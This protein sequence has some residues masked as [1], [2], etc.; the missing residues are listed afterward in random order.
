MQRDFLKTLVMITLLLFV[1]NIRAQVTTSSISGRVTDNQETI[2]GA[3]IRAKHEPTGTVYGSVTNNDGQFSINGVKT[4]GPYTIE[5][6]MFGYKPIIHNNITLS[7]GEN[8]NINANLNIDEK[9]LDEVVVEAQYSHFNANKN[10]A[11]TN[12]SNKQIENTPSIN[13]SV[14]DV[15]KMTPQAVVTGS[16]LSFA[17]SNNKYNSFQIDGSVN[18]DVFGLS[19][20]GTNGGLSGANPISLEAIEEIQVV[21]APFDVRQSGF[22]GGGINAITKS[23]TNRFTGSAYLYFN[24][25]NF[26][27]KTAG[28]D[29]EKREKLSKQSQKTYGFTLGGPIVK[30][31]LFFF[32]NF[33]KVDETYPS[34]YNVGAGS[35]ITKDEAD[36][37]IN[38]LESLT[39]GYNGGGYGEQDVD[40]KSTKVL[41]RLDWN[42]NS[43]HS[44]NVRYSYLD[45]SKL[46]Y[47]NS[48]NTLRL[49]NTG[50]NMKNKSHSFV[51]E[52]NSR[53][54]PEWYNEMRV[55]YN[56]VRDHREVLG[57]PFP[58][59]KINLLNSRAVE[60]G[61]ER[62]SPANSLDQDI[63]SFTDNLTFNKGNHALTFGTHNE[64]FI[65]KNLF[66]RENYGS[67]VYNSLDDF[68]SIG[69]AN[70]AAPYEY[71][72]SF[73]REDITGSK[74]WAP[75]FTSGQLG[76]YVQDDWRVSNQFKLTYGVRMDIPIF[77][78]SP[79]D[80]EKFNRSA[81]AKNYELS[82][83]QMP[84]STPLFSP[85]VGF[86]WNVEEKNRTV[87]RGGGGL[88]TGRVPFVWISNAFSNTGIEYSRTRIKQSQMAAAMADG[89]KF[90]ADPNNQYVPSDVMTSEI[91]VL[92]KNFKFPQVFR[93]NLALERDLFWGIRGTVEALYSKTI[94]NI[95]Y[96]NL[97]VSESGK[98][99]NNG[100]DQ[101]PIYTTG[102]NPET[103]KNF[104][105]DYT[106]VI[107][108]GNTNEGYTYSFTGKLEKSFNFGLDAMIAYTFGRSKAIN[109]GTSSQ[110]L[111]NWQYNEN[112]RGSNNP[113]L[114]PTDF[115]VP[116][117][118]VG[119][120]SYRKEYGK[121]FATTI[122]LT[123]NGQ[124]GSP[125]SI[126]YNGDINGDGMYG[127]DVMYV[128]TD[129]ELGAMN[130][131]DVTSGG[132]VVSSAADQRQ[133]FGDW[134]NGN[135]DLRN[136][137][138]EYVKRNSIRTPFEHHFD[139][140]IA[141]DFF[142][143]VGGRRH[144][145]QVNFDILN[146][147]NLLNHN[148]GIY[149]NASSSYNPLRVNAVDAAGVPTYQ[150]T[151]PKGDNLYNMS[152]F[153]SR[154]RAQLG[155][156]YIF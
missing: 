31:K 117:R 60:L 38:K 127:N 62:Y 27:G 85:R 107:Y 112:W 19:S 86:R 26:V 131:R 64:F 132:A 90:Q 4:G 150:F 17:G 108:L 123:Y 23:G 151:A 71:N 91:D 94:N 61:T 139:L 104:T 76:F 54:S 39:G 136:K 66:I 135:K 18:N 130:F 73:S 70:E 128:P 106:G 44:L 2:P 51:A 25:Q 101:R 5:I 137:K 97:I 100:G 142:L 69:T 83:S 28:K 24:N 79:R 129:V 88:F 143:N 82:T 58:Y 15:A 121:H 21:I 84:K 75:K 148:W 93:L 122:G 96:K 74:T 16:G 33:E 30:D 8:Y 140:H 40:T 22:T 68:L 37:I 11:A 109:D 154:W 32:A 155:F 124:S 125:Y 12:F 145:L 63:F 50:Y 156:K 1:S 134:I 34:S 9:S 113:E 116:H 138:G 14:Y 67:Y 144:T 57:K 92:D 59:V 46:N 133:A 81:I 72:Y 120:L 149:N 99:L 42:I 114:A 80:N 103:G 141:Q 118:I 111:S 13:R 52:L 55:S 126:V 87:I 65:M 29:V 119:M 20:S 95:L 78:D 49:N 152:D 153:N 98:Y 53:F 147:G 77:F 36:Q 47:S 48:L 7:L 41:A 45:A 102:V 35:N 3:I 105:N 6:S 43:L 115:D 146:V 10:G 56:R 89:F 110:A